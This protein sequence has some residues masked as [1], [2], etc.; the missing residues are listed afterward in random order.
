MIEDTYSPSRNLPLLIV[1]SGLDEETAQI[2][3]I[4]LREQVSVKI[5]S[6]KKSTRKTCT[7]FVSGVWK[8]VGGFRR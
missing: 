1:T 4:S 3:E 6:P 7:I 8:S 2:G 5:L